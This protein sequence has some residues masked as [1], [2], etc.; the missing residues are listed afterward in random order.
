MSSSAKSISY[1][2]LLKTILNCTCSLHDE[3]SLSEEGGGSVL[4]GCNGVELAAVGR[5]ECGI[6]WPW[7]PP[8]GD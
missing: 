6:C 7:S 5:G 2:S 4:M 1:F 3:A 8:G